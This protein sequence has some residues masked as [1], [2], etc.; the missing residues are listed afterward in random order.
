MSMIWEHATD[1]YMYNAIPIYLF[2]CR[3]FFF[4]KLVENSHLKTRKLMKK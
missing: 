4:L 3:K 1:N 2:F